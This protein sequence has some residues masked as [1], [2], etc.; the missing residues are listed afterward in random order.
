MTKCMSP[1]SEVKHHLALLK[2]YQFKKNSDSMKTEINEII[3]GIQ[4][5]YSIAVSEHFDEWTSLDTAAS[6]VSK[7]LSS[8]SNPAAM[9]KAINNLEQKINE[10]EQI[11]QSG[12]M[13]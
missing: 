10:M 3:K 1:V 8:P 4:G 7:Q 11:L 9:D 6:A 5:F 13:S 2:Q 12:D